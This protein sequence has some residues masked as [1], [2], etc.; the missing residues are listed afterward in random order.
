MNDKKIGLP[1]V[2]ATGVGLIV[3]TSC[4]LSLGQGAGALGT[5]FIL[6]M[7]LACVINIF[8]ALCMAELNAVM[9][10]LTGGLAQYTLAGVGP[11]I[12]IVTMVGGYLLCQSIAG[13]VECAMFGNTIN[14]VFHTGLPSSFYCILLLVVLIIANLA[15][16]DIFAKIQDVVVY[17]LIFSLT[18]MGLIGIFNAGTGTRVVQ[19]MNIS[20]SFADSLSYLGLGFFL[21]IGCEFV[22][23]MSPVTKNARRNIPLSMVLSLLIICGMQ[24]LV[25]IGMGHYTKWSDLAASSS[26]HVLY[27][28]SMLGRFGAIWMVIVSIFAV[29]STVNSCINFLSRMCAGLANLDMLPAVFQKKNRRG[30][31]YVGVLLIGG[32]MIAINATGLS[33]SS[34]LSF[35]ILVAMV[36]WLISYIVQDFNVLIFRKRFPKM[37]RTF[38]VPFGPVIPILA[39]IGDIFIIFNIDGNP[40]TRAQ[41]Y[42]IDGL[43]F[44][45]LSVYALL[46]CRFRLHRPAFKPYEMKEVMAMENSLYLPAHRRAK[47]EMKKKAEA[48]LKVTRA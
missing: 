22:I 41:I 23:P 28:E 12:T 11:F 21:F 34:S 8:T 47:E 46:W 43:C 2:I 33:N 17:G 14:S 15:G 6:T 25:V 37:P 30:A 5:G 27:G 3:A 10:N 36:F 32:I 44:V 19:Q 4:L 31:Y 35:M 20:T 16:V 26:P 13:S 42:R 24:I 9:P 48:N 1:S 7:V 38:K 45:L 40:A 29:V 39:I 18:A